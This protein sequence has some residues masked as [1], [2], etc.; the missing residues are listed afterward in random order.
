MSVSH[1]WIITWRATTAVQSLLISRKMFW[2]CTCDE[3]HRNLLLYIQY[4]LYYNRTPGLQKNFPSL[5]CNTLQ[6]GT[7]WHHFTA[8]EVECEKDKVTRLRPWKELSRDRKQLKISM[9]KYISHI[10]GS[11]VSFCTEAIQTLGS[12]LSL[13]FWVLI[14]AGISLQLIYDYLVLGYSWKNENIHTLPYFL[15]NT[16]AYLKRAY[17]KR[18]VNITKKILCVYWIWGLK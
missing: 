13:E 12:A 18:D 16:E 6:R 4:N 9:L 10:H 2:F 11:F 7:V 1:K 5:S 15:A 17:L 14:L 3:W 8:G